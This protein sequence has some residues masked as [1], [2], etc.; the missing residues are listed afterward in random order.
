MISRLTMDPRSS[1]LQEFL[2]LV[3]DLL[4]PDIAIIF[5]TRS[6]VQYCTISKVTKTLTIS[7]QVTKEEQIL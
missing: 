3:V 7:T 1:I 5:P 4:S 6:T 2:D